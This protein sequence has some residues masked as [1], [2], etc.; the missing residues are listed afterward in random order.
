ML[1]PLCSDDRR[2]LLRLARTALAEVILR[3]RIPDLPEPAGRLAEHSGAFVTL[4]CR[5]RL[6]GCMG[7][8][9][10]ELSLSETVV[11]AAVSAARHDPRFSAVT[12]EELAHVEIEISILSQPWQ[13]KPPRLKSVGTACW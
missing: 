3:N 10:A 9:G 4:Y 11:Q 2:R 6:R 5:G 13:S 8:V 1:P 12:P 7:V